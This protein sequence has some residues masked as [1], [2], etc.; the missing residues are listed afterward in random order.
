MSL[1]HN[2]KIPTS[3]LKMLLDGA[4][5]RSAL[6]RKQSSNS[7]VDPHLWGIGTGSTTGYSANGSST[8][9]SRALRTD[10]WGG[11]SITW[12]ST[13]DATSGADG[14]WNSSTYSIDRAFTYRF[15]TW[16]KRYTS[17]TGGTFYFGLNPAIIRN[18]T[19]AAQGN[20]YW[21]CP[22]ISSLTQDR[23]Y[24][25]VNH[26]FYE[27]YTGN[28]H[29]QSGVYYIDTNGAVVHTQDIWG[30]NCGYEDVRWTTTHTGSNHR[31]YHYYTTNTASG[32][33][34]AFPRMDK[35][36]GK[37]PSIMQLLKQGEGMWNDLSG[38][39]NHGVM[40]NSQNVTWS[41]DYGG[42]FNFDATG[43]GSYVTCTGPNL[44]TTD[45]TTIVAS[46]YTNASANRG[47]ILSGNANNWLLGHHSGYVEAHYGEGWVR[48]TGSGSDTSWGIHVATRDH[49]ADHASYWKNGTKIVSNSTAGSQGP[50]GFSIGRWYGSNSQYSE[51]QVGY[52]AAWDRVLTD[53]EITNITNSLKSRYGL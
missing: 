46:R 7:L 29:P 52:V 4:S 37:Q 16:I 47:R 21:N 32:I 42:V 34:W 53:E 5:P 36:D 11:T 30:C 44:N 2:Q 48:N 1:H 45:S 23:W 39:G 14:G 10:P 15:S 22:A 18:D 40:A 8:E 13:P 38:N 20:P 12:R 17:G 24:L 19:D 51:A 6:H 33:E 3:G 9:Q 28:R 50:N 26:A 41:A 43:N 25:V 35:I 27:G 49:S 31:S